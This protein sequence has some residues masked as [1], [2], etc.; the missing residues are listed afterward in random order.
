MKYTRYELKRKERTSN[1]FLLYVACV[2]IGSLIIGTVISKFFFNN[3][4]NT[5]NSADEN[6]NQNN[7]QAGEKANYTFIQCGVFSKKENAEELMTELNKIGSPFE[8]EDGSRIRVFF[9]IYGS[10]DQ[11]EKAAAK[12][13]QDNKTEQVSINISINKNN[14]CDEQISDIVNADLEVFNKLTDSSVK[15]IGTADLKKWVNKLKNTEE[16]YKSSEILKELK[17]YIKNLPD[18]VTKDNI[19]NNQIFIYKQ[20][21]KYKE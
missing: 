16:N 15:A 7:V 2:L 3:I 11:E 6:Y 8:I 17:S 4:K 9:G 14:N 20:L 10:K 19:K 5:I 21:L 13:L 1:C 12:Q 18:Q